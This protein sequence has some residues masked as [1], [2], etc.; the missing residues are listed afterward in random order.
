MTHRDYL[1]N[2]AI[3][4]VGQTSLL[5]MSALC[6]VFLPKSTAQKRKKQL[7]IRGTNQQHLSLSFKV[8]SNWMMVM[9]HW[10][11]MLL[12]HCG[13]PPQTHRD[14]MSGLQ[15]VL[16]KGPST[17]TTIPQQPSRPSKTSQEEGST[18]AKCNVGSW[19]R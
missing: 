12:C 19:N 10:R 15:A 14:T 18:T 5:L 6:I 8:S 13:L 9:N 2:V 3:R 1:I 4:E 11:K 7:H 17:N 16:T